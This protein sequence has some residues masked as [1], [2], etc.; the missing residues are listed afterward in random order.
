MAVMFE[1]QSEVID[2]TL[3]FK[4]GETVVEFGSEYI[5]EQVE[6]LMVFSRI[7]SD[8]DEQRK[9]NNPLAS[10]FFTEK[11]HPLTREIFATRKNEVGN[12]ALF[13]VP[14]LE[15]LDKFSADYLQ[16]LGATA[17]T[18]TYGAESTD[19]LLSP[20]ISGAIA[21]G[22]L[23]VSSGMFGDLHYLIHDMFD[24]GLGGKVVKKQKLDVLQSLALFGKSIE[25][26]TPIKAKV[27]HDIVA[28]TYDETSA[29]TANL[30]NAIGGPIL[31]GDKVVRSAIA[32]MRDVYEDRPS[33]L[34]VLRDSF[35][36]MAKAL[37]DMP[38]LQKPFHPDDYAVFGREIGAWEEAENKDYYI[39]V[40]KKLSEPSKNELF[41]VTSPF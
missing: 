27:V 29:L 4:A 13:V 39:A 23:R 28:E 10:S 31:R 6:G 14:T 3:P 12:T 17:F 5:V 25:E 24:H 40:Q 2:P 22:T 26:D 15:R 16:P 30:S 34:D 32:Y 36:V 8:T 21:D 38:R 20:Q 33:H 7:M 41:P 1:G 19:Y 18:S 9:Q 11:N 37:P 35:E